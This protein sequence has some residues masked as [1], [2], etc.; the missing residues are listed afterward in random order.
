MKR[1]LVVAALA[2]AAVAAGAI[3]APS[4][5]TLTA[6]PTIVTYGKTTVLTGQLNPAQANQN[7]TIQAAT[8]PA[9]TTFKK[10]ATVKTT[11]TGAFTSTLTPTAM[12]TYQA[13][14]HQSSSPTVVVKVKP[15]VKLTRPARG[16]FAVTVTAGASLVG[17]S[18]TIQRYSTLRHKWLR[19]KKVALTTTANG[20]KPTVISSAT[21][22]S[23][24][25]KKTRVRALLTLAQAQPCYIGATSNTVRA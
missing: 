23:K 3:A 2:A 9:N 13:T 25:A 5:L 14:L 18:L 24:L 22:K 15:V 11:S 12:T 7:I 20:T 10:T 1:M 17:K 16:S 21:F 8:C 4:T 19:V 6:N